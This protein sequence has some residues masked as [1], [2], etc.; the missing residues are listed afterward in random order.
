MTSHQFSIPIREGVLKFVN[1]KF[2]NK[3][4]LAYK[5][6]YNHKGN[7]LTKTV[8][9]QKESLIYLIFYIVRSTEAEGYGIYL[10]SEYLRKNFLYDYKPYL[11][12]L[13][14]YDII[15]NDN[16]SYSAG[17]YSKFYGFT[18]V[19]YEFNKKYISYE[20]TNK[21]LLKK[22]SFEN[23]GLTEEQLLN[24]INSKK[25]RPHL[26][27]NF[28]KHLKI[29]SNSAYDEIKNLES[30]AY[31]ANCITIHQF[32]QQL[33]SYKVTDKDFRLHTIISRIKK[34][35]LKYVTY[36]NE[37][38]GE[39]D[40]KT[41]QPLFL[42]VILKTI[43]SSSMDSVTGSYLKQKLGLELL[44]EIKNNGIDKNELN[45]FGNNILNHDLYVEVS[46]QITV[47]KPDNIGFYY[48]NMSK[49]EW[50][51]DYFDTK[52]DLIKNVVMR[53]FYNGK[54]D[55]VTQFK[56][57]YP[58]IF[59]VVDLINKQENITDAKCNLA[60]ILQSFEAHVVLDL[61]AKDIS[62]KYKNIPLFSKHDAIITYTSALE[63]V[64]KFVLQR[65]EHY[66]GISKEKLIVAKDF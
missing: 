24:N 18:N 51:R 62:E 10:Q 7:N 15:I 28:D 20:I 48:V 6:K 50:F 9:L 61:I 41:S 55:G 43:F 64:R 30:D 31:D 49:D 36:K 23:K 42:Y 27:K 52:R 44:T 12:F 66:F 5:F 45:T 37:K 33:W 22:V 34:D 39:V 60:H 63:D 4:T 25:L 26:V 46:K 47:N 59:K 35:L 11:S 2:D 19:Y 53:S 38:L 16:G 21:P 58:S 17:N 65:F 32:Q 13:E 40:F 1:E 56:K 57:L 29:D 3:K 14:D 8:N 54:G